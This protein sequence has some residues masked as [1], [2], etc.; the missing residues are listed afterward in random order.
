MDNKCYLQRKKEEMRMQKIR[1]F[2]SV[3]LSA[4]L[5]VSCGGKTDTVENT[6]EDI[7][8]AQLPEKITTEQTADAQGATPYTAQMD[9]RSYMRY[10]VN[11]FHEPYNAAD[12]IEDADILTLVFHFCFSN[13]DSL[14]YVE[15]DAST[16]ETSRRI[17]IQGDAFTQA[18]KMLL[19]DDF[20][21]TYYRD[22]FANS[23]EKY[24]A[25]SNTYSVPT[26]KDY[27]GGDLYYIPSGTELEISE[28][29]DTA[30]VIASVYAENVPARKL[31]YSFKKVVHDGFLFYQIVEV[32]DIDALARMGEQAQ[33][34][35]DSV[36]YIDIDGTYIP[37]SYVKDGE[38]MLTDS[39]AYSM[40]AEGMPKDVTTADDLP[41]NNGVASDGTWNLF[42]TEVQYTEY[43]PYDQPNAETWN[44]YFAQKPESADTPI[45][46]TEVWS[47]DWNGCRAA[48][49][50]A[51]NVILS[52]DPNVLYAV[53]DAHAAPNLP[54]A[55][56]TALYTM[57]VL[58]VEGQPPMELDNRHQAIAREAVDSGTAGNEGVSYLPAASEHYQQIFSAWQ[59]DAS[60]KIVQC[61]IF[62]NMNGWYLTRD[63]AYHPA[64]MVC[65]ID[66]DGAAELICHAEKTSSD[67]SWCNVYAF[68]DGKVN[69]VLSMPTMVAATPKA[70]QTQKDVQSTP[71]PSVKPIADLRDATSVEDHYG[72]DAVYRA[73]LTGDG[74]PETCTVHVAGYGTECY[75]EEITVTDGQSGEKICIEDPELHTDCR[76]EFSDVGD[77]YTVDV[78]GM[79]YRMEKST[80]DTPPENLTGLGKG[81]IYDY[82]VTDRGLLCRVG[83]MCGCVEVCGELIYTYSYVDGELAITGVRLYDLRTKTEADFGAVEPSLY[84][85]SKLVGLLD[86]RARMIGYRYGKT[87]C[88]RPV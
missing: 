60:G 75:E 88:T 34:V 80:L 15:W 46:I 68:E 61:P 28:T 40:V 51:S 81:Q 5:L 7:T 17:H 76:I 84:L 73:D 41:K 57:T 16:A 3:L 67:M 71:A 19:G 62:N 20:E 33:T 87:A 2:V 69:R 12:T 45:L 14:D 31:E 79:V 25:E 56:S 43:T 83:L 13:M 77:A 30:T 24:S 44:E 66:G 23:A 70:V 27:W 59:Y 32:R 86:I 39:T 64:C 63:F 35:A 78:N 53:G 38:Q 9:L 21:P 6:T 18:A 4:M 72:P 29:E 74:I 58:F 10:F 11:Y 42:P 8:T 54:A 52:G 85:P 1:I 65:D 22:F 55:E 47:F 37:V 36:T 82:T 50:T 26:A 49:V 48:V